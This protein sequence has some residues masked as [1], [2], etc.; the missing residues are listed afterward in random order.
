MVDV[1]RLLLA[2]PFT[3]TLVLSV[4]GNMMNRGGWALIVFGLHEY[5]H[6][7]LLGESEQ[8]C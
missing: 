5:R 6:S 3:S 4:V 2:S 8:G 1:S 7:P